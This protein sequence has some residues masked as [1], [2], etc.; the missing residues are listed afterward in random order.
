[1]TTSEANSAVAEM[2]YPASE[3]SEPVRL[4]MT[5]EE[6]LSWSNE[7]VHA[8][9]VDG[10]VIVHMPPK[11][12]HQNLVE[13]LE[14]LLALYVQSLKLGVVRIAPFEMRLQAGGPGWEPDIIVLLNENLPRLTEERLEGPADLIVEVISP[15]SVQY[16]RD[17]KWRAYQ[18]GG[19]PEY[20]IVDSRPGRQRADFYKRAEQ[21]VYTLFATEDDE[22][23]GS[24]ILPGFWLRP[25][26]LWAADQPSPMEALYEMAGVSSDLISQMQ[27]ALQKGLQPES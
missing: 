12:R 9:W 14:R 13:F 22:K 27:A 21:G 8:E 3:I 1:V 20:W 10:E 24:S 5:Y 16:D 2:P 4:K 25:A 15:S 11:D 7:D 6:F 23:V 18:A 19:V 17:T 26:W